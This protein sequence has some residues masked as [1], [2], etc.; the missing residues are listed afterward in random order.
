[1]LPALGIYRSLLCSAAKGELGVRVLLVKSVVVNEMLGLEDDDDEGA[2]FLG[3]CGR[4]YSS[5]SREMVT[6][7]LATKLVTT[8]VEIDKGGVKVHRL[9]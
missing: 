2:Q 4:W 1:V 8:P 5:H 9:L 6:I 7:N 3:H